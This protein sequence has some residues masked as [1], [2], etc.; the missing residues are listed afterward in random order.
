MVLA[1]VFAAGILQIIAAFLI[2]GSIVLGNSNTQAT[3]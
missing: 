1:F 2:I 3:L